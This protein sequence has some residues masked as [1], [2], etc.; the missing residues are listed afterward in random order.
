MKDLIKEVAQFVVES[1][2]GARENDWASHAVFL[3][4]ALAELSKRA[5]AEFYYWEH[6][7]GEI[8]PILSTNCGPH[9]DYTIT[10]LFT[11][12]PLQDIEAIENRVAEAC[13]KLADSRWGAALLIR[14]G[15]WR[16]Y[17]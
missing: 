13:A 10:P 6:I 2:F 17:K 12:P 16:K 15:E 7:H 3:E 1:G 11:F 8:N 4:D 14:S 9:P 5:E